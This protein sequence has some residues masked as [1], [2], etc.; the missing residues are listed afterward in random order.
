MDDEDVIR[1]A[2]KAYESTYPRKFSFKKTTGQFW[3]N[4][5]SRKSSSKLLLRWEIN[6]VQKL[7][8]V[9]TEFVQMMM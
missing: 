9:E 8:V 7:K 5:P 2:H 6:L 1:F 4:I 3:K